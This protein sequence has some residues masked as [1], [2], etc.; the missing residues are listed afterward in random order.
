MFIVMKN[1]RFKVSFFVLVLL[2]TTTV[3]FY[4]ITLQIMNQRI[5]NE[6]INRAESL[7]RSISSSAGY[8]FL[9]KDLLGLDNIVF[10]IQD[11]N[12]DVEYIAI[13]D[14]DMKT[15]VH[16]DIR[17]NG[18][19]L[20][21]REGQI[22]KTA[23][24]GTVIKAVSGFNGTMFEIVSPVVFMNKELGSVIL[25]I[26]K[27][28][29]LNAQSATRKRM[30]MAF[31]VILILGISGSIFLSS[32]LTKPIRELSYGVDELKKGKRSRTLKVYT[33]DELGRLTESFNEMTAMIIQ[34]HDKI[35]K[36]SRDLEEAYIATLRILA[37]A[38]DARDPYTLGHSTRV[39]LLSMQLAKEIGFSKEELE[40]LEIACLFHDVGKIKIPDSILLKQYRLDSYEYLEM[41]RH[42]EYGA[43]ILSKAPSLHN[44]IQPIR[45]HHEWYNGTGYPDGLSGDN[46]P[47]SAAIIS[48]TDAFDAMTSNRP[49]RKALPLAAALK[50]LRNFSGIQFNPYLVESF[51]KI[52]DEDDIPDLYYDTPRLP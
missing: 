16:S 35:D 8:S 51:I 18:E 49:Y 28:S 19:S 22:L 44:L 20:K 39:S 7:S 52:M 21:P 41:M 38:I 1:I 32:Y 29:L 50:E 45:H 12:P 40:E 24:N 33:K 31:T 2:V 48:I 34:Q 5:L 42:T 17:K 3:V 13:I 23:S 9:S 25:G 26:N 10:K 46:I 27:S 4:F 36:Y 47:L 30:M 37:A 15:I 11:S 43:D 6:V 14:N